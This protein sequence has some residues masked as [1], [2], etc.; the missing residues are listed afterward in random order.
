M[1][2]ADSSCLRGELGNKTVERK[3][4]SYGYFW[5]FTT[6]CITYYKKLKSTA[7]PFITNFLLCLQIVKSVLCFVE[8][9]I[10]GWDRLELNG[11]SVSVLSTS[12]SKMSQ[13]KGFSTNSFSPILQTKSCRL[14]SIAHISPEQLL[15]HILRQKYHFCFLLSPLKRSPCCF[16]SSLVRVSEPCL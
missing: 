6:L 13:Q 14:E 9:E 3:S 11:N 16:C 12:E 15:S 8:G 10:P 7:V 2:N 4:N 5:I 1:I